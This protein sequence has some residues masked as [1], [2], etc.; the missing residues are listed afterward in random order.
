MREILK[1]TT[2]YQDTRYSFFRSQ[3]LDYLGIDDTHFSQR[4]FG[5][6]AELKSRGWVNRDSRELYSSVKLGTGWEDRRLSLYTSYFADQ[7]LYDEPE[8]RGKKWNGFAGGSQ[9]V[10]MVYQPTLNPY[11]RLKCG[12]DYM[13]WASGLTLNPWSDPFPLIS[14]EAGTKQ[15]RFMAFTGFLDQIQLSDSLAEIHG[16]S[17]ARRFIAG[18]RI[19]FDYQNL[20][21]IGL[22]ELV[23]Y[24]G[25]QR[26]LE[27]LYVM[28]LFW[29]HAEQL[30]ANT[31]DNTILSLDWG[32]K[33]RSTVFYGEL[34]IDDFQIESSSPEDEEPTEYGLVLGLKSGL[35]LFSRPLTLKAQYD[36]VSNWTYNQRFV[37]NRWTYSGQPMGYP[38]GNDVEVYRVACRYWISP[39]LPMELNYQVCR[40]GEGSIEESWS[41]PWLQPEN[42][43]KEDFPS[44]TVE[45]SQRLSLNIRKW[46]G[47]GLDIALCLDWFDIRNYLHQGSEKNTSGEVKIVCNLRFER[48][49]PTSDNLFL[50][51]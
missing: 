43:Y 22:S 51:Y 30:N 27:P 47:N 40:K 32:V 17:S 21:S 3:I 44:G 24:G 16:G 10:M 12:K 4:H 13:G 26:G 48:L 46:F 29:Y 7:E 28:P 42:H 11:F 39:T 9:Q 8:Y 23:L 49:W 2:D 18:H 5:V 38:L 45:T 35:A 31:N 36:R 25:P 34:M 19:R 50:E 37:W 41:E 15:F 1:A 14:A 6:E 33:Y 20:F